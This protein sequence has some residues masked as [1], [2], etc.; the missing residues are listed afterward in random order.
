MKPQTELKAAYDK[1]VLDAL[2]PLSVALV[3]VFS[4]FVI[5]GIVE[6]HPQPEFN[7]IVGSDVVTAL[8]YLMLFGALTRGCVT[9]RWANATGFA[10]GIIA[11]LNALLAYITLNDTF[12]LT[13]LPMI[14]VGY[15]SFLLSFR[16]LAVSLAAVFLCA[17]IATVPLLPWATIVHYAPI[18]VAAALLS[19]VLLVVRRRGVQSAHNLLRATQQEVLERQKLEARLAQSQRLES[20]GRLVSGVAHDFNNLLT[21][22]IGFSGMALQRE[23][24]DDELRSDL[25]EI[26]KAGESAAAL[27]GKLL[28]FSSQQALKPRVID[29]NKVISSGQALMTRA[30]KPNVTVEFDLDPDAG[31]VLADPIQLEQVLLNLAVN[32]GDAMPNGGRLQ[33]QTT[34]ISEPDESGSADRKDYVELCVRDNGVGMSAEMQDQVFDPFFTTKPPGKGTGLGLATVYGIIIQSGGTIK[35]ESE[36]DTGTCIRIRLP[37]VEEAA[38]PV[39]EEPVA[40]NGHRLSATVLLTD[41]DTQV[42]N[43]VATSLRNEGYHV[44]EAAN[45]DEAL[46]IAGLERIDVLVTDIIMQG[47]NGV[48]LAKE[49]SNGSND[50]PVVFISGYAPEDVVRDCGRLPDSQFI[51][52]PFRPAELLSTVQ[53]AVEARG[54]GNQ[55]TN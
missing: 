42:R 36:P 51:S 9:H 34:R 48:E 2:G 55:T 27:T 3:V 20:V 53:R 18:W 54:A 35:I 12:Y 25:A 6:A 7:I 22:V 14:V 26:L 44:L 33:M 28:A 32:A 52:K 19:T 49:L 4:F 38:E 43:M 13:Y 46:D 30:V 39:A 11:V 1:A 45:A 29:I 10:G 50:L 37:Y 31:C 8:L 24:E 40:R 47:K 41:D 5:M 23:L 21:P 15:G 17:L 16:W